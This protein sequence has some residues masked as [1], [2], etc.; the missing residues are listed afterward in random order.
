MPIAHRGS[1]WRSARPWLPAMAA[2][3]LMLAALAG[4]VL[5]QDHPTRSSEVG[6]STHLRDP[7]LSVRLARPT[8]TIRLASPTATGTARRRRSFGS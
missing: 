5:A 2:V 8:T 6:G 3:T 4:P 1:A 7:R